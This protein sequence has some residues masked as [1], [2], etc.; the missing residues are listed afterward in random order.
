LQRESGIFTVIILD[1]DFV[2]EEMR[3]SDLDVFAGIKD[4]RLQLR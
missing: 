2:V 1:E 3:E 4:E